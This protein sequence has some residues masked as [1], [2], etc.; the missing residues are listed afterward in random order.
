MPT[1]SQHLLSEQVGVAQKGCG[2]VLD[3]SLVP[4]NPFLLLLHHE[5]RLTSKTDREVVRERAQLGAL[6]N[7]SFE[8]L[9][10]TLS[11]DYLPK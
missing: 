1:G 11:H 4:Y 10:L 5:G 2:G 6:G 3:F 7:P 9:V 8:N